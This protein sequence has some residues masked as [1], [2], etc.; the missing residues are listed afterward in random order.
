M[1]IVKWCEWEKIINKAFNEVR[2]KIDQ[3]RYRYV[4][5]YGGRGSSKSDFV[6]KFLINRCISDKY[7]RFILIRNAYNTIKDSQYQ[8]L[9]D[10]IIDLGLGE[11]FEFKLQPLEIICKENGN[12][13]LARGC[14]DTTR[15]K[16]IKDP[17]GAW[18]EEDIPS[19]DDFITITT[20]IRTSKADQLLEIFT[21]NPEVKEGDYQENWFWK[22]F[23]KGRGKKS[24]EDKIQ[25]DIEGRVVELNYLVHHSTYHDNR[26]LPP[27]FIAF[28]ETLKKQDPYYYTI[29]CLGE[30]GNRITG[31]AFYKAFNRGLTVTKTEYDPAKALHI[32]FDFNVNPYMTASIWQ[33]HNNLVYNVG[34]IAAV[35]PKNTTQGVCTEIK[36]R[37]SQ[38]QS[39]MFI[40]GDPSGKAE[41]T[42]LEKGH[43]DFTIIEHELRDFKPSL[44][45]A[46]SAPSVA[47]RGKWINSIFAD[48]REVKVFISEEC[49]LLIADLLNLKEAADGTKFKQK[50][51]DE[52]TEVTYEKYGHFTD[53]MDYFLCEAFASDYIAFQK[54]G[55]AYKPVIHK[56]FTRTNY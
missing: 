15:L 9:K 13:F 22:K 43:N 12:K 41:D 8:T 7:F 32:T 35:S 50:V 34:E 38:H 5:L 30:W 48:Q 44:R 37:Y 46:S 23:F 56:R 2:K 42:R 24:F 55:S 4:I 10:I 3:F 36:N 20:S 27:E 49:P 14:D 33:I 39:G 25:Q 28:L 53:G 52:K 19:E 40:Y 16:S 1:I 11:L 47:M 45:I 17:T 18:Y 6:A 26:W 31:G 21:I 54:G 29:Y 51:K